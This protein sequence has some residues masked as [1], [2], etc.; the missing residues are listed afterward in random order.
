MNAFIFVGIVC[1]GNTCGFI[2]STDYGSEQQCQITKTKF[3]ESEV[4]PEVTFK[5]AQCM[6]FKPG[7]R[8]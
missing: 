6:P 3:L 1:I 5:A 2:T 8:I 7:E 4:N